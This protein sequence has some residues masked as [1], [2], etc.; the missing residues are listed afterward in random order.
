MQSIIKY[1]ALMVLVLNVQISNAQNTNNGEEINNLKNEKEYVVTQERDLL[2]KEVEAINQRLSDGEI[3]EDEAQELKQKVAKKRALNIENRTVIIDNKIALLERNDSDEDRFWT[4]DED[5]I[6]IRIKN[7]N[8]YFNRPRKYDRRTTSAF[9]F[10]FGLNNVI[11]DGQKLEDSPYKIG[12]SHFWELGWAWKRRVFKESNFLRFKYG[13]SFQFNR[14]RPGDNLYFVDNGNQTD[15]EVF[16]YDLKRSKLYITN[17][18]IPIHFE[19]GSSKKHVND[20]YFRYST[21]N[22]FKIGIGGYAG[23]KFK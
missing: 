13:F 21:H 11:Q 19:F 23:L 5:G 16:Q 6:T 9:V 4:E 8:R 2:K 17:L 10:A 20:D 7:S 1:L 22:R 3:T 18:V 12:S 14:L 15:L